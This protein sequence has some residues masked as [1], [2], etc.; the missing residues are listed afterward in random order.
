MPAIWL[1]NQPWVKI[2]HFWYLSVTSITLQAL[3]SYLLMRGE[4]RRRLNFAPA[5]AR[6]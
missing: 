2:E 4:M 3:I 1:A 5:G 6:A